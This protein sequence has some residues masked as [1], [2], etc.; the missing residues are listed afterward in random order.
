MMGGDWMDDRSMDYDSVV[1]VLAD[2]VT[3]DHEFGNPSTIGVG[4][5]SDT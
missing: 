5:S 2:Y 4:G 1:V 3:E